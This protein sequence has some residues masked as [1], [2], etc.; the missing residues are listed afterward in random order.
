MLDVQVIDSADTALMALDP[1]RARILRELCEPGSATTV[2]EELD[3]SRQKVNYHLRQLEEHGLVAVVEHRQKRGLTERI[4]TASARSYALSPEVLGEGATSADRVDRLSSNYLIAVAGDII[5]EVSQ[6]AR[7]AAAAG[8]PL[9]TLTIE[10]DVCFATPNSRSAFTKELA[11]AVAAVVARH[12]DE[13]S[14][15]GRWHRVI[16]AAHPRPSTPKD[17]PRHA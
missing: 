7:R 6:L 3:M 2:A 12:H 8:K 4:V 10:T 11:D 9:A 17:E 13:S 5:R 16:L 1:I 14:A 15:A